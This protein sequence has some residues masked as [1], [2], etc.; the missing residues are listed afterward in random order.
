MKLDQLT[1]F[2]ETAKTQHIGKASRRLN[3]SPS[4]ISHS[5]AALEEELGQ[6]LFEKVG[7]SISLSA[8]GRSFAEKIEL[9]L[10]ALS[11]AKEEC[12]SE[13]VELEGVFRM[14]ATHGLAKT[15]LVPMLTEL[16]EEHPKLVF[17]YYSLRSAQVIENVARGDLDFG[18]CFAPTAS[19]SLVI[20]PL[21]KENLIIVVKK[22]HPLTKLK[23]NELV[24]SLVKYPQ[25]S[26]K[27]FVGIEVCEE[28]PALVRLGI[29][30]KPTFIY[31]SYEVACEAISQGL[32]W[33]LVPQLYLEKEN[34]EELEIPGFEARTQVCA[35]TPKGRPLPKALQRFTATR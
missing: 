28:H 6:V 3:V 1:Y 4:A 24:Q 33:S 12:Q 7:K 26:P 18:I 10:T 15:F 11:R 8:T 27:A 16:A 5:I 21:R 20:Y 2:L 9:H 22:N 25:A 29:P 14:A 13:N 17:E 32:Y 34:L 23:G 31:D 30:L 19:P 35:I